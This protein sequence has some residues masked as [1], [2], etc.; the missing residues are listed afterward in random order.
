M[1]EMALELFEQEKYE[2]A[3]PL[4]SQL[5]ALNVQSPEYNFR[6][7][8]CQLFTSSNKEEALKYLEFA[9]K[10]ASPPPLSFFYYG[11]GLHLNYRFAKAIEAYE[12]YKSLGSKRDRE[13]EMVDWLINQCKNGIQLVSNFTDIS[14]LHQQ[15]LPRSDFYRNYDLSEIG[16][17]IIVK[18]EDFMSEEDKKRNARFI[19]YYQE[20]AEYI[21]YASYSDKNA[22]GKDLYAIQKLPTGG[23]SQPV[24]LSET[25]NTPYDE[26]YPFIHPDGNVL[27]F[28][29]KGHNSMGGYDIF[30]STRKGDGT[31][32]KPINMEFAINT[33]WDEILFISDKAEKTAWFASNRETDSKSVSVYKIGIERIPLNLT[34]I[35][36]RF[37]T[38]GSKKAK[39][40]VED[41]VQNK[42][43][44]VYESDRQLGEYLLDL[45]GSGKYKFIVEA[46]ESSAIHTGL[47]EVPREKGLKQFR[48]EMK[49]INS[50]GRE[51][52][53]IINH[54]DE[55]ISDDE[56]LLSADILRRQASLR[57]NA[58]EDD[59]VRNTEIRD[60]A[61][62]KPGQSAQ[63]NPEERLANATRALETLQNEADDLA[64]RATALYEEANQKASSSKPDDLSRAALAAELAGIYANEAEMR[65]SA[66]QR[67]SQRINALKSSSLDESAMTAQLNSVDAELKQFQPIER[68]EESVE[69]EFER[70]MDPVLSRYEE[71]RLETE[72]LQADLADLDDEIAYYRKEIENTR[73][74]AIKE[75]LQLQIE[76]AEKAKP[77]KQAALKRATEEFEKAIEDK[78]A[79]ESYFDLT[80][81]LIEESAGQAAEVSEKVSPSEVNRLQTALE[82][83]AA[84]IPALAAL[85]TP[86]VETTRA[87]TKTN[88]REPAED[89]SQYSPDDPNS[90]VASQ[91]PAGDNPTDSKAQKDVT[92]ELIGTVSTDQEPTSSNLNEEIRKIEA[93]ETQP[94]I[95]RG[96]YNKV[97]SKQIQEAS[98]AED[99]VIAESRKA[100]IYDQWVDNIEYRVDSINQEITATQDTDKKIALSAEKS[101]LEKLREEKINLAMRSYGNIAR[102]TDSLA[103]S[104]SVEQ[105]TPEVEQPVTEVPQDKPVVAD[106][107]SE[108]T[109]TAPQ[110]ENKPVNAIN[111]PDETPA[112]AK[113]ETPEDDVETPVVPVIPDAEVSSVNQ[114]FLDR[115]AS[116]KTIDDP[117][118]KQYAIAEINKHWADSLWVLANELA[119]QA[120]E[121]QNK[122]EKERLDEVLEATAKL[123]LERQKVAMEAV[124]KAS[125]VREEKEAA[126]GQSELQAQLLPLLD[127]YNPAVFAQVEKQIEAVRDPV[128][129]KAQLITLNKT[130]VMAAR[131]EEMRL[132]AR[133]RNVD[134]QNI[135]TS[136]N[137]RLENIRSE[138]FRAMA[139]LDSLA[140]G[141]SESSKQ[142]VSQAAIIGNTRYEG[143]TP[144]VNQEPTVY[145][146]QKAT[147]E[148]QAVQKK[149]E[150]ESLSAQ[151][152]ET[153]KKRER[154]KL[155]NELLR[156]KQEAAILEMQAQYYAEAEEKLLNLEPALLQ[157]TTADELPSTQQRKIAEQKR[158]ESETLSQKAIALREEA[159]GLKKKK[160]RETALKAVAD[161]EHE[162]RLAGQEADLHAQLADQMEKLELKAIRENYLILPGQ[163]VALPIASRALNPNER[164]DVERTEAFKEYTSM[165]VK[166]DSFRIRAQQLE[167]EEKSLQSE[168]ER[169][170]A[171]SK[172]TPDLERKQQ[173]AEVAYIRFE[174]ADSISAERA[175]LLRKAAFVE[176]EANAALLRQPPEVYNAIVAYHYPPGAEQGASDL[177][178]TENTTTEVETT[179]EQTAAPESSVAEVTESTESPVGEEPSSLPETETASAET[180]QTDAP[181]Q[182]IAPPATQETPSI[183]EPQTDEEPFNL[184]PPKEDNQRVEVQKDILTNTIFEVDR[185]AKTAAYNKDNPIPID[186]PMPQGV[187]YRVQIG[188]FRNAINPEI[189]KGIK[190]I[191]GESVGNGLT[192][193]TV[194]QFPDFASADFA[195]D[196]VREIGYPDAFVVAYLNGKRIPVEQARAIEA[197]EIAATPQQTAS[198]QP[199]ANNTAPTS[200]PTRPQNRIIKQGPLQ[201]KDVRTEKGTYLTVQVGVFSKPVTGKELFNITPL[202]QE[203][204]PNGL[205]RYTTGVYTDE[206]KA[207]QARDEIRALGITD[208]FVTAYKNGIRIT[209]EEAM[210]ELSGQQPP[211]RVPQNASE[212]TGEPVKPAP[213]Q[214][215]PSTYRIKLGTYK[216]EI[217]VSQAAIILS[218]SS[219]GVD[220]ELNSDGSSTY[221]YGNFSSRQEAEAEADNLR[222]QGMTDAQVVEK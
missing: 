171:E 156:A 167:T 186:A 138:K 3:F 174:K 111:K 144:V 130:W 84:S 41:V 135:E 1:E 103:V 160:A 209:V 159:E 134:D 219:K 51:Q 218:L 87:V 176:N 207:T 60:A 179:T 212:N 181:V 126:R 120:E 18:P 185:T 204:L 29:S 110:P 165:L 39:I 53:Q 141:S 169:L 102:L 50:G 193:Y 205:Y 184:L 109:P 59:I 151:L 170:I 188:A 63:L 125:R 96:N 58:S 211:A 66:A 129:R 206:A 168:G 101:Q 201:V 164:E 196:E 97:F 36:G 74:E 49:L 215:N 27:Y 177:A 70:R 24:K 136:L 114:R 197:G 25:I 145:R 8:A 62:Y 128:L 93:S 190:P 198:S 30:K 40:T 21:Y 142:A 11:R 118:K 220:K 150:I 216:G 106:D 119:K 90:E 12:K 132:E 81:N 194:G 157:M 182:N 77:I 31:W 37:E 146:E 104:S 43:I 115:L 61:T 199:T 71:K 202:M 161:I 45:R 68:F 19:M 213:K 147:V 9:T 33:P 78:Q 148:Q 98:N 64:A 4:Y 95:V 105:S 6:F 153:K 175:R 178:T 38:E 107:Q 44:G 28:A 20:N 180:P 65:N 117:V 140:G 166:A 116:V 89:V 172:T 83:R 46:E 85:I 183:E 124:K 72:Q 173:L 195:K 99:P 210:Q 187:V 137:K 79:V 47:V 2:E 214:A 5:L 192:R 133:L 88:N 26:D 92:G 131:N 16:G 55:P 69:Q 112:T 94:Q 139:N 7:G 91:P 34:I 57:V 163:R 200:Q 54:F 52:L 35:Q 222:N 86:S 127:N 158:T 203:S 155:E 32:T 221:L 48:Q 15:V 149:S 22:T 123:R 67:V 100:E 14:V 208:A 23:W 152:D 82:V 10:S 80:M 13:Y 108:D 56:L 42:T 154:E 121:T 122:K 189:F 191:F 75:E 143:Y 162:S 73:D 17:K 113:N 217:P 76:E